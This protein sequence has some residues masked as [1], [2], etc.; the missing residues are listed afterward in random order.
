MS[1]NLIYTALPAVA[2]RGLVMFPGMRLHFEIGREKSVTAIRAAV[3]NDQKVFLVTQRNA[4]EDDPKPEGLFGMGVIAEIKQVIKNPNSKNIRVVVEGMCR[5]R[6]VDVI[7]HESYFVVDVQEQQSLEI[8]LSR[9]EY[10]D[11][12]LRTTKQIFARYV[13]VTAKIVPEVSNEVVLNDDPDAVADFI[14]G[15]ALQDCY[16]RQELLEQLDPVTR[17]EILCSMLVREIDVFSIEQKI[18]ERVQTQID[19]NQNEYYLREKMRAIAIELGEGEDTL[20]EI[21]EYKAKILDACFEQDTEQ[22]LLKECDKLAKMQSNS[23]DANV[24]R[25]YLDTCLSLPWNKFTKDNLMLDRARKVLDEDHYGMEKIKQRFIEMLAVQSLTSS[26]AGQII[27]LVGPPGVGKTSIVRSIA[28]A[29]G[30][31]YVRMSLGGV[32]DEAEIRG[33]RKTYVGA[34]PGRLITSIKQ[35][36]TFNP[37]ILLDEIDKLGSDYKGD[38]SSALLEALDPE[39]NNAFTDHYIEFPVDLSK[40]IFITTA[41]DSSMIPSALYDRMEVIDLTSYTLEDK[42]MIAKK[43]FVKKQRVMHG[44]NGNN[45]RFSDDSLKFLIDGYT[46]EAGVRRLEQLIASI[47]RKSAVMI[48]D[49]ETEKI[50]VNRAVIQKMLGPVKFKSDEVSK[51]DLIGVVN[52]LAWTSVGGEMLQVETVV[53]DGNGKLELTGSL[54][55]VMKESA[56]AAHSF[57]RSVADKYDIDKDVFKNKDIHIHVPQGAVPKD[58]PSAGVTISTALLSALTGRPVKQSVAMTGEISLT[59]RVMPIGGLKEK[60]MA[61]FKSGIRTVIIPKDNESDLW[62]VDEAVKS[63]VEFIAVTRLEDVFALAL[64]DADEKKSINKRRTHVKIETKNQSGEVIAQ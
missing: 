34:M 36:G 5:A 45:I 51:K 41:N 27:C 6:I 3:K 58:G 50:S 48:S 29:M 59:G 17:L 12:M 49:G 13:E 10:A 63:N 60:S 7:G 42:L 55:D 23:V 40:V 61:A 22:K 18:E 44:L 15:N 57:I 14:A 39:Q 37:I 8:G 25:T 32:R 26:I 24:I 53:M 47:C 28:R 38:P 2:L 43:H 19:E 56:K 52:G 35:A 1:E 21:E 16:D 33:H 62:E 11:A 46:R 54:G 31:K 30:R 4:S 20:T 9:A 64:H